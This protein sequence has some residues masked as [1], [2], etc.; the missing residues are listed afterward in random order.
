[1]QINHFL[2]VKKLKNTKSAHLCQAHKLALTILWLYRID[3]DIGTICATPQKSEFLMTDSF[4]Q[5]DTIEFF[6][7]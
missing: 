5:T 1:M 3:I 6:Y 4:M 7:I 2:L